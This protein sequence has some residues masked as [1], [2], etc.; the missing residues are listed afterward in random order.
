MLEMRKRRKLG[1]LADNMQRQ[2]QPAPMQA[3]VNLNT[4]DLG[5]SPTL[6]PKV[7]KPYRT[8]PLMNARETELRKKTKGKK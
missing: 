7:M 3:C 5:A 1:R 8:S 4:C 6:Q 2:P